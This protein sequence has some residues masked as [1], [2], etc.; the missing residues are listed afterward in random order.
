[1]S[2]HRLRYARSRQAE[3]LRIFQVVQRSVCE[4]ESSYS[5]VFIQSRHWSLGFLINDGIIAPMK[6]VRLVNEQVKSSQIL[7]ADVSRLSP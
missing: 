4:T 1:M 3:I 2:W 6:R 5:T 7:L